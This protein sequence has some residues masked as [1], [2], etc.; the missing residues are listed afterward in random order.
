M[1]ED[2][3]LG[4]IQIQ[5]RDEA[6]PVVI[7][8]DVASGASAGCARSA[9]HQDAPRAGVGQRVQC[10]R[11]G[12]AVAHARQHNAPGAAGQR[13]GNLFGAHAGMRVNN[14]NP[15]QGRLAG[16]AEARALYRRRRVKKQRLILNESQ[17]SGIGRFKSINGGGMHLG[18]MPRG[19]NGGVHD[20]QDT[21]APGG[22]TGSHLHGLVKIGRA[23]RGDGVRRTHGARQDYRPAVRQRLFQEEGGFLHGVRAVGDDHAVRGIRGEDFINAPGEFEPDRVLHVL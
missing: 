19:M 3:G 22:R 13:G 23:V 6:A 15:G 10:R 16:E 9:H 17:R 12:I 18:H 8:F 1:G 20:Q 5:R 4:R 2:A 21:P 11:R 7:H 14:V